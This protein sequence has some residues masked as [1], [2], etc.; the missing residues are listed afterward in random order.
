MAGQIPKNKLNIVSLKV[1]KLCLSTV[2]YYILKVKGSLYKAVDNKVH[3]LFQIVT[4]AR[5]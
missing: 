5:Q 3:I 4:M 1:D 2:I